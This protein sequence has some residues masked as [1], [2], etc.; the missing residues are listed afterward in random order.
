MSPVNPLTSSATP[1]VRINY[2]QE[3]LLAVRVSLGSAEST[4]HVTEG[5]ATKEVGVL[6]G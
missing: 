4:G 1:P 2:P 5:W 6:T 3:L